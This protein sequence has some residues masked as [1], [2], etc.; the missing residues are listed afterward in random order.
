MKKK[1]LLE[2]LLKFKIEKE[3]VN[4]DINDKESELYLSMFISIEKQV[5]RLET[6]LSKFIEF[7]I[8]PKDKDK[9]YY[10]LIY[11][12]YIEENYSNPESKENFLRKLSKPSIDNIPQEYNNHIK[13]SFLATNSKAIDRLTNQIED[14]LFNIDYPIDQRTLFKI[15]SRLLQ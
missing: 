5:E 4:I 11:I 12:L 8:L 13:E 15:S 2:K 14:S 7:C 10:K 1:D 9:I 6:R 3:N